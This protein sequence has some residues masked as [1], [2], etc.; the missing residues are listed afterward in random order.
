M[1]SSCTHTRTY[2]HT[3]TQQVKSRLQRWGNKRLIT[4]C[5]DPLYKFV[6]EGDVEL[7]LKF[8]R[9]LGEPDGDFTLPNAK[10]KCKSVTDLK[11]KVKTLLVQALMLFSQGSGKRK[12]KP[13]GAKEARSKVAF[14]KV[15]SSAIA[16][17]LAVAY[18]ILL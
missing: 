12:V 2:K 14:K 1:L 15:S 7:R 6:R 17:T 11:A 3:H 9:C 10:D 5:I 4:A 18:T 16:T 13:Y 8:V